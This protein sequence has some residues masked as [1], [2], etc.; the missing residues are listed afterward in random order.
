M[1]RSPHAVTTSYAAGLKKHK[2]PQQ[3]LHRLHTHS[4]TSAPSALSL[5]AASAS[6]PRRSLSSVSGTRAFSV[7]SSLF[8]SSVASSSSSWTLAES[9]PGLF[10]LPNL[11]RPQDFFRL[12]SEVKAK[13]NALKHNVRS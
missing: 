4:R 13:C 6:T 8:P 1:R 10:Q 12:A 11:H 9:A 3:H 7:L 5:S 2:P